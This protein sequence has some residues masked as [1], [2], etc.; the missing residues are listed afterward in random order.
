MTIVNSLTLEQRETRKLYYG[1]SFG[2]LLFGGE[3]DAI[4]QQLGLCPQL[5]V[6]AKR[7]I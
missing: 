2:C 6:T 3:K 1:E 7:N 4:Q 5:I